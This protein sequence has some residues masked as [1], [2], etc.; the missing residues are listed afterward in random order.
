MF[1]SKE[2]VSSLSPLATSSSSIII[3]SSSHNI[4]PAC[5]R[6]CRAMPQFPNFFLRVS[7]GT[8]IFCQHNKASKLQKNIPPSA[9]LNLEQHPYSEKQNTKRKEKN[10]EDR[11][12][13]SQELNGSTQPDPIL[14][15]YK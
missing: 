4:T 11:R 13:I 14:E 3:P 7:D 12:V 5:L 2:R 6:H 1:H 10:R 9:Q 8:T 15:F